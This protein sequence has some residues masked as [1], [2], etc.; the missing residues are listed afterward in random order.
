MVRYTTAEYREDTPVYASVNLIDEEALLTK[1][2]GMLA[3]IHNNPE[4]NL[5]EVTTSVLV[6]LYVHLAFKPDDLATPAERATTHFIKYSH[7]AMTKRGD[8]WF[9]SVSKYDDAHNSLLSVF[10]GRL[11][12]D[13]EFYMV[14][15]HD[16]DVT[17]EDFIN[18]HS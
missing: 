13:G 15:E 3:V 8:L 18:E 4:L 16:E 11:D 10:V 1:L 9:R 6:G 12:D 2:H 14:N 5:V 17:L 7:F